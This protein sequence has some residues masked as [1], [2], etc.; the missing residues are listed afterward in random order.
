L[1]GEFGGICYVVCPASLVMCD[2]RPLWSLVHDLEEATLP[3]SEGEAVRY[4]LLALDEVLSGYAL[5]EER[6][7]ALKTLW[8]PRWLYE[9]GLDR[10]IQQILAGE[11]RSLDLSPSEKAM[12]KVLHNE[13]H[14]KKFEENTK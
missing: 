13:Y 9:A 14:A 6:G 7:I 2:E 4:R 12:V 5:G 1:D 11:S 10:K 3:G 8:L